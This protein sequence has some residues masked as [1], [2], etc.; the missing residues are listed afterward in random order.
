MDLQQ[1]LSR[2]GRRLLQLG[3][4]LFLFTSFEGFVIPALASPHLGRSVHT[5]SGFTGVLFLATG[6]MWPTLKLGTTATRIAFWFL[7]YSALATIAGFIVAAL[8]GAGGSIMPIAAQGARGSAFQEAMIQI[9]MYPAA[10]TGIVAFTLILWGLRGK[11][12]SAPV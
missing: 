6:L 11:A 1:I 8:W 10:P 2:Q 9:V 12:G 5:L 7:I 4:V 3:V